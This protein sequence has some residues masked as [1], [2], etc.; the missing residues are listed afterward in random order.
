MDANT[1]SSRRG[2]VVTAGSETL[3][4]MGISEEDVEVLEDGSWRVPAD[5]FRRAQEREAAE[6]LTNARTRSTRAGLTFDH[7]YGDRDEAMSQLAEAFHSLEGVPGVRPWNV[8]EFAAWM[9][10]DTCSSA[11]RHAA[12]FV[13]NVW[14]PASIA[15]MAKSYPWA[16]FDLQAAYGCWDVHNRG[17]F[18]GWADAPWWP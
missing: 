17:A 6:D 15:G 12:L 16:P 9:D 18:L 11:E 13:L 2:G 3:R 8:N 10:R 1:Q 4:S 14:N 7:G 5:V